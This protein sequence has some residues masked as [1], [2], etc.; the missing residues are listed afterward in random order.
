MELYINLANIGSK[1]TLKIILGFK[2]D[3]LNMIFFNIK[4]LRSSTNWRTFEFI[5]DLKGWGMQSVREHF[6]FL[7]F[8]PVNDLV[9]DWLKINVVLINFPLVKQI[10]EVLIF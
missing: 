4:L 9:H 10:T 5:Y 3:L 6:L 8:S 7:F 1:R 2:L